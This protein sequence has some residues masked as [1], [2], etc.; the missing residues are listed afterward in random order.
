MKTKLLSLALVVA[1]LAS[2]LVVVPVS[3]ATESLATLEFGNAVGAQGDT[4]TVDFTI[5][6]AALSGIQF[7]FEY[8]ASRLTYDGI[9]WT[10][11]YGTTYPKDLSNN[12]DFVQFTQSGP[13]IVES[14]AFDAGAQDFSAGVL[15]ATLTFTIKEDAPIGDAKVAFAYLLDETNAAVQPNKI[16]TGTEDLLGASMTFV[17]G[18]VT[19]LPEG[20]ASYVASPE[21]DFVWDY[22][23]GEDITEGVSDGATGIAILAYIGEEGGAVVIPE[24]I[25]GLPVV[26][27]YD[28]AFKG[29]DAVTSLVIPETVEVV[30]AKALWKMTSLK[31]LFVM[32][33]LDL[34]DSWVGCAGT[35]ATKPKAIYAEDEVTLLTTVYAVEGSAATEYEVTKNSVGVPVNFALA[36]AL[37]VVV[38]EGASVVALSN[39]PAP[40]VMETA[41]GLAVAWTDGTNTYAAGVEM[42]LEGDTTLEP[43]TI[44][45]PVM[46]STVG[47][48]VTGDIAT[49]RI[50]YTTDFAMADYAALAG[51]GTVTMGT[52]ITPARFVSK[53]GAMTREALD[54]FSVANGGAKTYIDVPTAGYFEKTGTPEENGVYT[55]AGSLAGFKAENIE[56]E[57][58]AVFYLTVTT[59]SG[60][61]TVYS[62]FV[63]ANNRSVDATIT[64]ATGSQL[65]DITAGALRDMIA[66][67]KK[68]EQ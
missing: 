11:D 27:I 5:T 33:D 12:K 45:K 56:L 17:D 55:F 10:E 62:D 61:F 67:N 49:T 40:G 57:Y 52:L 32:G 28:E 47:L 16:P 34:T 29:A 42:T 66:A 59:A 43:V 26:V 15:A 65:T 6:T 14:M 53:A 21:T 31:S 46:D 22:W 51:F 4:V 38:I 30:G 7:M 54:A 37:C 64:A 2:M 48:L 44:A 23:D 18:A 19:V 3:G 50:R 13:Y 9:T 8:D 1:M 20:Y 63:F 41:D 35:T 58:A 36:E 25:E 39:A 24:T 60:S 68:A